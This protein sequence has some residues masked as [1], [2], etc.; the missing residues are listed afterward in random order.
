MEYN[1]RNSALDI[2]RI[3]AFFCVISVH[4][5][6]HIGFYNTLITGKEMY[7]M[8]IMRTFFMVCVPLFITLSGY[9]LI[10]KVPGKKYYKGIIKTL[11]IYVAVSVIC[12]I[13]KHFFM[14]QPYTFGGAIKGIL[15]FTGANYSWYIEMYIGLFLLAPFLNIM[16]KGAG[17]HKKTLII[18]L[19]FLTALPQLVNGY[20]TII[21]QWW[22]GFYPVTYYFLG[23]YLREFPINLSKKQL[24][25]T[26]LFFTILLGSFN[27]ITGKNEFFKWTPLQDYGSIFTLIL[28]IIT[29]L[30]ILKLN[31]QNKV[32]KKILMY[33]SDLTLGAYLISYVFD[34]VVYTKIYPN[35]NLFSHKI[36]YYPL[37]VPVIAVCSLI[38]SLA[39]NLLYKLIFHSFNKP[40]EKTNKNAKEKLSV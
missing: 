13:F 30:F 17:K 40:K 2:L 16:Y 21:P 33:I 37:F 19:I 39:V 22:V 27:Y 23:C 4:F 24:F 25:P 29:F 5:F 15:N 12:I 3:F 26:L 1:S 32:V 31:P 28:T 18:T 14:E 36:F 6:L 11:F 20:M 35:L 9:L 7:I 34:M 8:M 10:N 38:G